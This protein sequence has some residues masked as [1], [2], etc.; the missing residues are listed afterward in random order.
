MKGNA[1]KNAEANRTTTA[2]L[3]YRTATMAVSPKNS[4][5]FLD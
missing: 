1:A 5:P 2:L 3:E 4:K